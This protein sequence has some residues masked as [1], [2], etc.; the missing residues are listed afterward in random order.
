MDAYQVIAVD[1]EEQA[2]IEYILKMLQRVIQV[3]GFV[4]FGLQKST[5]LFNKKTA[6]IFNRNRLIPDSNLHKKPRFVFC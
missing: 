3:I 1:T 4:L 6:N 2:G 5:S